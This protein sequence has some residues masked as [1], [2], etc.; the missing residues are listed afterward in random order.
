M[1]PVPAALATRGAARDDARRRRELA[2]DVLVTLIWAS[3]AVA[4]ALYLATGVVARMSS[5]ADAVTALGAIA[6]LVA[7][8]LVLV[9]LILAARVPL[10]DRLVGHDRALAVHRSLGKPALYLLLAHGAL[11]IVGYAL[12]DGLDPV[13][14]AV[15]LLT[16][17]PD[18]PT[19]FLAMALFVVIVVSSL[20][21]VR[22]RLR[23]EVWHGIHLLTYAAVLV[24]LPH[25]LSVGSVFAEGSAQRAYW[26]GL[27]VL[28]LGCLLVFRIGRPL[29]A[30]LR[31]DL[32]VRSVEVVG[33]G[34]VSVHLAGRGLDRL[35]VQGGQFGIWRFWAPG[36]WWR[37]HPI[38]F[39]SVP[40]STDARITVRALGR[41]T[42]RFAAL[43]PG[44]RVLLEGPYGLFTERARTAPYLAVAAAG[45]GVTPVRSLLE[46]AQFAPGELTVLLRAS[47]PDERYLWD[48][49]RQLTDA[50]GGT[51]L[52]DVGPRA[53]SGA[54]WLSADAVVRGLDLE[55]V[56][57]NLAD[58]DLYI[59]G[60]AGWVS[61][62]EAAALSAGVAG[63]RIRVERFE[64]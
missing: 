9:M 37:A 10:V 20:V 22:G 61:A 54:S 30:S 44:T 29:V 5:A 4:V 14:E 50:A 62:V 35:R 27:Y 15:T 32:R 43:A 56:F 2:V 23:Y 1:P 28:A 41:G 40:T 42:S 34:V 26:I 45:I 51:V 13:T 39:S 18:I 52:T 7:T 60:P 57:P 24:A 31:H 12:A 38:S 47:R 6:G 8:D 16:T 17:V 36:T 33:D 25:Q 53:A 11:V 63:H 59:C 58:S 48:E 64:S 46:H 21:A 19:A 55:T 3:A 49:V